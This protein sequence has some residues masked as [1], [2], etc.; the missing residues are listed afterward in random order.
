MVN[1]FSDSYF[2]EQ[3]L[4]NK[5]TQFHVSCVETVVSEKLKLSLMPI[6]A[7][8]HEPEYV[9]NNYTYTAVMFSR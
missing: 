1:F 2:V 4:L 7:I 9:V 3:R 6:N 8:E 5:N